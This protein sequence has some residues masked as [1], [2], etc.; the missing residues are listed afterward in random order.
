M[1]YEVECNFERTKDENKQYKDPKEVEDAEEGW[2]TESSTSGE[3]S[4]KE[5]K[6]EEEE[7]ERFTDEE[8]TV[9][10]S[11]I[12]QEEEFQDDHRKFQEN[13]EEFTDDEEAE[14]SANED[15]D[16]YE[17]VVKTYCKDDYLTVL[18]GTLTEFRDSSLLTDLTLSTDDGKSFHVHSL[19]LA[20]VSFLI[21]ESL[22]RSNVDGNRFDE[23][24]DDDTS[25]GVH[26]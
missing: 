20:A 1:G 22:A 18:F 26:R 5:T 13:E 3:W 14:H 10:E 15:A 2:R 17:D 23:R 21:R 9:T 12:A 24:Q 7:G 16:N 8:R 4:S 19:V 6:E 25:F 11:W